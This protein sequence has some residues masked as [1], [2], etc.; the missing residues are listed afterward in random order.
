MHQALAPFFTSPLPVGAD[1]SATEARVLR[2]NSTLDC[3]LIAR[4]EFV[5][6]ILPG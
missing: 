1:T 3:E 2:L 6:E 5:R 4:E